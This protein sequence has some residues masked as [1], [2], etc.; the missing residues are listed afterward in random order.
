MPRRQH[1]G[2]NVAT[3]LRTSPWLPVSMMLVALLWIVLNGFG[4]ARSPRVTVPVEPAFESLV[5]WR[6]AGH[7]WLLVA[8]GKPVLLTIYDAADGRPLR[9]LAL[10]HGFND[11]R[12]LAQHDGRLFVLDDDG[13]LGELTLPQLRWVASS[14]P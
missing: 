5:H 11:V 2:M 1:A 9:R 4:P 12:A 6:D 14:T 8:G 3:P 7:D 13:R 10:A